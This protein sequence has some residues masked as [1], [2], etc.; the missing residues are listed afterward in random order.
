MGFQGFIRLLLIL[1][2]VTQASPV[3]AHEVMPAIADFELRDGRLHL[4][5]R[6]NIEGFVAGIDLTAVS[7]TNTAPQAMDYDALRALP[8]DALEDR[9]RAFWPRMAERIFVRADGQDVPVNLDFVNA[10]EIGDVNLA[11]AS[12][13]G[14]V[15]RCPQGP[16]PSRSAGPRN[17]AHL[18][19]G[20]RGSKN[21]MTAFSRRARCPRPSGLPAG[22]A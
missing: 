13:S 14:S 21:P 3:T 8:P 17:S 7:D 22:T 1:L 5:I 19:C 9:F 10:G 12:T 2:T 4:D 15:G 20:S 11:R 6:A 16:K 18:S